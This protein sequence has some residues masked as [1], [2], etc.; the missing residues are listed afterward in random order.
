LEP[1]QRQDKEAGPVYTAYFSADLLIGIVSKHN[2]PEQL[3]CIAMESDVLKLDTYKQIN[4][5]IKSTQ[6]KNAPIH[7]KLHRSNQLNLLLSVYPTK[8]N[9]SVVDL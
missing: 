2:K 9:S 6:Y 3:G 7:K 8:I 1:A 5:Q 4:E